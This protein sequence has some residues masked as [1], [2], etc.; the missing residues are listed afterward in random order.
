MR[1]RR[2]PPFAIAVI[3]CAS[4]LAASQLLIRTGNT[5]AQ[6]SALAIQ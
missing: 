2:L 6:H 3:L 1:S 5:D 4:L